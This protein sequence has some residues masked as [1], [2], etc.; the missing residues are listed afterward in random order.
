MYVSFVC[1]Y[2][3]VSLLDTSTSGLINLFLWHFFL[4]LMLCEDAQGNKFM[5]KAL[6]SSDK[7]WDIEE[8]IPVLSRKVYYLSLIGISFEICSC[9]YHLYI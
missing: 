6:T 9:G 5:L 7:F 3:G 2:C 1:Y 8:V 4:Q